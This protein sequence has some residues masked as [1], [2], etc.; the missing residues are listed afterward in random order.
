MK[1]HNHNILFKAFESDN[2]LSSGIY[3]PDSCKRDLNRGKIVA[4]GDK[5]TRVKAGRTGYRV[6][7]WGEEI[8]V[9]GEKYFIMDE[10]SIIAT[11]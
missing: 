9:D 8:F 1:P 11:E 3:V 4:I 5:V 6:N 7:G 10:K 2:I